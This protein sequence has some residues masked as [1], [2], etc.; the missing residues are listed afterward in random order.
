MLMLLTMP[1]LA[2]EP[3]L[4]E[5]PLRLSVAPATSETA[6]VDGIELLVPIRSVP[7]L[8]LVAPV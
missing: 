1:V 4:S 5:L 3:M 2:S 6:E 8:M 7:A